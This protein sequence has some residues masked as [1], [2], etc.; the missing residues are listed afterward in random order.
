[1]QKEIA[2]PLMDLK[3]GLDVLRN[4][5]TFKCILSTLLSIGVFLNGTPAKGFQIEY[6]AKVPEVKDTVCISN[7]MFETHTIDAFNCSRKKNQ[8]QSESSS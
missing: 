8:I 3:Q 7:Q 1:M 2:E 5:K 4:N 6:L